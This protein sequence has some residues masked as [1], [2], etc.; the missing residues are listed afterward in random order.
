MTTRNLPYFPGSEAD[1][2]PW[3]IHFA[4]KLAF[5]A[6]QLGISINE[7]NDT[8]AD[9]NFYVWFISS[10]YPGLQNAGL[11][12]TA[13]KMTLAMDITNTLRPL[14]VFN[15]Y[16]NA[17]EVRPSG[18]LTRLFALIQRIKYS[19]GYS[20]AIGQDLG[21]IGSQ[22]IDTHAYPD[23]SLDIQRNETQE[24]VV[25]KFK[26]YQH[27]AVA[28]ESRRTGGEWEAMGIAL[29][30]PWLDMRPLLVA[31]VP[32]VREYRLR[33]YND[34]TTTGEFSPIQKITVTP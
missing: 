9:I 27:S 8:V 21:I 4:A 15:A 32:E 20:D 34:D 10:G 11:E 12:G 30:S 3:L 1:S 23:L 5:Y 31:G 22:V 28:I 19:K 25:I 17:P 7:V 26:K 33:W 29:K 2:I 14:P 24:Y 6:V 18:I 16:D 13:F